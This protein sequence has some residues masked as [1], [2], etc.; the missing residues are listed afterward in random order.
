MN[1]PVGSFRQAQALRS[2]LH[3]GAG[4][5]DALPAYLDSGAGTI[6]LVEPNPE[7]VADLRAKAAQFAQVA[8]IP[9]AVSSEGETVSLNVYN[10]PELSSLHAATGILDLFP[11]LQVV[12]KPDVPALPFSDILARHPVDK[13]G[14][15]LLVIDAPGEEAI[16]LE[17]AIASGAIDRFQRVTIHC[18]ATPLFE[19]GADADQ[20]GRSLYP[21]FF[22]LYEAASDQWGRLRLSFRRNEARAVCRRLETERDDLRERLS[23]RDAAAASQAKETEALRALISDLGTRVTERDEAA[24]SQAK[25]AETLRTLVSDLEARVA[26]RDEVAASQAKEAEALRTLVSDLEAR[27]AER[28]EA[29]AAQAKEAETL[30]TL[31]SDLEAR[32][33]ERDEAAAAQAKALHARIS[34]LEGLVAKREEE[35]TVL[36]EKVSAQTTKANQLR[37][38]LL[39][40]QDHLAAANRRE[41]LYKQELVK[42]EAQMDLI[43]ELMSLP[44]GSDKS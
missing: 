21:H 34:D 23:E 6:T 9:A 28:D 11:G 26:E 4:H 35:H 14:P 36:N 41:E 3:I 43:R 1:P 29:A 13:T 22:D 37:L 19:T 39:Q 12:D 42:L 30:R 44:S 7:M 2:V 20:I 24:A 40:A 31:V 38:K 15:N 27:V 17:E 32:I 5:G 33:A 18:G 8:V 25:E 10:V 16:L